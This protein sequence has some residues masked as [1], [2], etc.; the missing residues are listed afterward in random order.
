MCVVSA[1]IYSIII[2]NISLYSEVCLPIGAQKPIQDN[3]RNLQLIKISRRIFWTLRTFQ[4][5]ER[6]SKP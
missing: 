4:N 5:V 1:Y 2:I 6:Q 3:N